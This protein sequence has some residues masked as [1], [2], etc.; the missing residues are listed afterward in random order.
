MLRY[1]GFIICLLFLASCTRDSGMVTE[2]EPQLEIY[3]SSHEYNP[4]GYA[5]LG[6]SYEVETDIPGR[7]RLTIKHID[8]TGQDFV[9]DFQEVALTHEVPILGLY[10]ENNNEVIFDYLINEKIQKSDTLYIQTP[11]LPDYFPEIYIDIVNLSSME[12]GMNFINYRTID[13]PSIFFA[14]DHEG[15]PRFVLDYTGHPE[16]QTLNYDVGPE[17]MPEGDFLFGHYPTENI[18]QVDVLGNVVKQWKMPGY[19]FHHTA[20]QRANGNLLITVNKTE[21]LHPN[22]DKALED[23][24]IELDYESGE[25]INEWD[26]KES[27]NPFRDI[28]G[29]SHWMGVQIDWAHCNGIIEDPKDNG[30]IISCRTQ[31]VV[32]LDSENNVQWIIGNHSQWST[33]S[34]GVDLNTKLL[35]P[36]DAAG[37]AITD[38][39][40]SDGLINHP[41][42][43]W[44]WYQHAP[45]FD[46]VGNLWLFDNGASRNFEAETAYSRAVAYKIDEENMTIQQVWQYGKERGIE[47]YSKIASDVD[48][49]PV[50]GN[51]L[52]C[53]G[54]RV[55]NTVGLGAKIVEVDYN[56]KEVYFEMRIISSGITFHRAERSSLYYKLE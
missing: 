52:F 44:P 41:D 16:L 5:P 39:D 42:F 6:G 2:P 31:G 11:D 33:N 43:E 37:N 15:H 32:K 35:Q 18:Y 30:I 46:S 56:T 36:L 12:P 8:G 9:H 10:F 13:D 47:T 48:V 25:L 26:L 14:L 51:I 54:V 22:G 21:S 1:F 28:L 45:S 17:R 3:N 50:T 38:P 19:T 53:P 29:V 20:N 49:E 4:T 40:V 24:I 7:L 23:V 34:N 27:L 55:E